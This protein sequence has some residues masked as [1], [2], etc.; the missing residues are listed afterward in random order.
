MSVEGG[1]FST[2][3]STGTEYSV[4]YCCKTRMGEIERG[5]E[6]EKKKDRT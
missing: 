6:K 3:L 4:P 5:K 1:T 2:D